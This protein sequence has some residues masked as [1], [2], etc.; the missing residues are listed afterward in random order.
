MSTE[1]IASIPPAPSLEDIL[2]ARD[3]ARDRIG[4]VEFTDEGPAS[5]P[6]SSPASGRKVG[7]EKGK[8]P[9]PVPVDPTPAPP[10][11][12]RTPNAGTGPRLALGA[13]AQASAGRRAGAQ[14]VRLAAA[15]AQGGSG[16]D[17][18]SPEAGAAKKKA[19]KKTA[20]KTAQKAAKKAAK[21]AALPPPI[22]PTHLDAGD[23]QVTTLARH[24]TRVLAD[25]EATARFYLEQTLAEGERQREAML[26]DAEQRAAAI[27]AEAER[28]ADALLEQARSSAAE[29]LHHPDDD[30]FT[31]LPGDAPDA[32]RTQQRLQTMVDSLDRLS[33]HTRQLAEA[34][35]ALGEEP[36]AEG[37]TP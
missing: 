19:G 26:V 5:G 3:P 37:D 29:Q 1:S 33:E 31:A 17:P 34:S 20:Q 13:I 16:T 35:L 28:E 27:V 11:P 21:K 8:R 9:G 22:E 6:E 7:P 32:A 2:G 4:R 10:L 30:L 18:T 23:L 14:A 15:G 25:V 12:V 24:V 36:D